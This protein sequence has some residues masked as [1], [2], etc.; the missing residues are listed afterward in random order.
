MSTNAQNFDSSTL[1]KRLS[2]EMVSLTGKPERY[3]MVIINNN[4]DICFDTSDDIAAY[5]EVKSIGSLDPKEISKRLCAV[6]EQNAKINPSRIYINM[7]DVKASM[8]GFNSS[9]FG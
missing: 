2:Q 5:L 6:L 1:S 7:E 9:T 4:V 3:V 8:W